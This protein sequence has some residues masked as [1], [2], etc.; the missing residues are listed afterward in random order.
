MNCHNNLQLMTIEIIVDE[1]VNALHAIRTNGSRRTNK[2]LFHLLKLS[3]KD[4]S[5]ILV[6]MDCLVDWF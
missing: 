5:D 2:I 3:F 1:R 6:V 4:S